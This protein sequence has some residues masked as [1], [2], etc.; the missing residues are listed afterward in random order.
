[1]FNI[2]C[3]KQGINERV[4][5]RKATFLNIIIIVMIFLLRN[6]MIDFVSPIEQENIL[7]WPQFSSTNLETE[8][9]SF[10]QSSM[11]LKFQVNQA[12]L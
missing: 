3:L 1:M 5:N 11:V 2:P 9:V 6:Y 12:K 4:T 7:E 8:M 10:I